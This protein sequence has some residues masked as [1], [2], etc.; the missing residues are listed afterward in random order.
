MSS[1]EERIAYLREHLSYEV[2]VLR[3]TLMLLGTS[4]DALLWNAMY[5]SF[6][7][8]ARNLFDFLRNE[9]DPRNFKASDFIEKFS[10]KDRNKIH[11]L[12]QTMQK[13]VLHLG[14]RRTAVIEEKINFD[15]VTKIAEW[16]ET[17]FKQF[18]D[19]LPSPYPEHWDWKWADP[20]LSGESI[21]LRGPPSQSSHP[22]FM[23]TGPGK[24]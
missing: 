12:M 1:Q 7:V 16:I 22:I 21:S 18:I 3:F 6:S 2:L 5:E 11:G 23:G 14:K 10:V 13:Q 4:E 15:D 17:A 19:E 9:K 24:P 20:T 8:H